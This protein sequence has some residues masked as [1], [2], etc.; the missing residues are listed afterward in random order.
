MR[1]KLGLSVWNALIELGRRKRVQTLGT[2]ALVIL[3]PVL[4]VATFIVLG[5]LV[6]EPSTNSLR[7]VLL[8]DLVYILV[9]ATLVLFRIMGMI[10]ARRAKSAGSRLHLRL[11]GVFAIVALVPTVLVAVFAGLTLSV[12]LE[13]W[14]SQQVREVIGASLAAAQAYDT[15]QAADLT[16]D[17]GALGSL[18][19]AQR[20][21]TA[22]MTDGDF[23][24]VLAQGQ[25]Q[26]QRGLKEA[27]VIDGGAEIRARGER[28]YLFDYEPPTTEQIAEAGTGAVVMIRDWNNDE[29]RALVAL[30][31]FPDR[32]L[33]VSRVV[34]GDLLSLLDHTEATARAADRPVGGGGGAGRR[35]RS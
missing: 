29:F 24:V 8:A 2:L 31:A 12:G 26:I 10:A 32:Y 23:R 13:G 34:D 7:L 1:P 9:L 22:V 20:R 15:E 6:V 17:A 25:A 18:L 35:R 30:S 19:D 11:T 3:G 16:E 4:A 21:N 33:L 5:P 28:S 14:F 27:Y